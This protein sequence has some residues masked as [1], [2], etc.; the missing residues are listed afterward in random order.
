[1]AC[2]TPAP[3]SKPSKP[4]KPSKDKKLKPGEKMVFG[5]VV[6]ATPKKKKGK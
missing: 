2:K 4:S 6:P 5:K 1:M 3:A